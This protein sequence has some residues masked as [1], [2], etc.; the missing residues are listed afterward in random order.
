MASFGAWLR[1]TMAPTDGHTAS[2]APRNLPHRRPRLGRNPN[3][4]SAAPWLGAE[5]AK[6]A[7]LIGKSKGFEVAHA[8]YN[9]AAAASFCISSQGI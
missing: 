7:E 3:L 6:H 4:V 9:G 5:L 1:S 8:A 2:V